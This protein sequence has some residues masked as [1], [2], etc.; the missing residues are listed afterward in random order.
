MKKDL[1]IIFGLFLLIVIILI[2]G[3]GYSTAT[4]LESGQAPPASKAPSVK[5]G[6]TQV[7]VRDLKIDAKI[8]S[9][10]SDRKKGLSDI[11]SLPLSQGM[12]FVFENVGTY[13]F[14]MKDMK[15]AIDIIWLDEN[16]K[17]V[18]IA[19]Y[20]YPEPG[21]KDDELTLYS[22]GSGAKYVLEINAG[23]ATLNGLQ[24]GGI[25]NFEL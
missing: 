20:A 16:K 3:R 21:K 15:F 9:K 1:A 4:F 11:D 5:S 6:Y 19:N 18:S 12:L 17:I 13:S 14:W 7:S 22:P 24:I 10:A 2:F 8:V 23:L 25:A